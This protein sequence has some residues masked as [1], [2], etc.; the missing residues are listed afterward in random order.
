MWRVR[1]FC[2]WLYVKLFK[3]KNYSWLS[4][5]ERL[6]LE[7]HN[8]TVK[9]VSKWVE[10]TREEFPEIIK[11]LEKATEAFGEVKQND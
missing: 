2:I 4:L 11:A 7:Y 10:E 3:P 6:S 9:N 1:E 8:S 5:K